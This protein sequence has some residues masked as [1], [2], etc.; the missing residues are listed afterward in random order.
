MQIFWGFCINLFSIGPLH[1]ISS[2][3]DFGFEFAEIFII[4]K[5]LP[6]SQSWGVDKIAYRYNFFKPLNKSMVIGH[7]I[8]GLFFAK[9][10]L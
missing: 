2:R 4:E 7:Y 3:S 10:V 9:L 6:D 5:R 1:Y 8:P